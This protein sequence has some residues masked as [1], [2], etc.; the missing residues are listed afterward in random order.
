MYLHALA[1]AFGYTGV[2]ALLRCLPVVEYTPLNNDLVQKDDNGVCYVY[3]RVEVDCVSRV[4][5]GG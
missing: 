3:H 5:R 2:Y 1:L 4:E